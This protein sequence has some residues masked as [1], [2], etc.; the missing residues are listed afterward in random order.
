MIELHENG[1]TYCYELIK[2]KPCPLCQM[3]Q[4]QGEMRILGCVLPVEIECNATVEA[5]RVVKHWRPE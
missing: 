3:F 5:Y 1:V 2:D 4:P